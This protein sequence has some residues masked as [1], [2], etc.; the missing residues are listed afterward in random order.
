ML[1]WPRFNSWR[2]TTGNSIHRQ[3]VEENFGVSRPLLPIA[4]AMCLGILLIE[5]LPGAAWALLGA[6]AVAVLI[7]AALTIRGRNVPLRS[8]LILAAVVGLSGFNYYR[9]RWMQRPDDIARL[10]L[11]RAAAVT[12]EGRVFGLVEN[13]ERR[14][15]CGRESQITSFRL[16]VESLDL[17]D[18]KISCSGRLNVHVD[19]WP[20]NV[21]TGDRVRLQG[22][23][24]PLSKPSNPGQF[25]Y[26]LFSARSGMSG[27]AVARRPDHILILGKASWAA[28]LRLAFAARKR[29]VRAIDDMVAN[30]R[31]ATLARC[32]IVGDQSNLSSDERDLMAR[33]GIYHLVVVSGLHMIMVVALLWPPLM[34]L[35]RTERGRF[36]L[37]ALVVI[38]YSMVTG[39]APPVVRSA[40][41]VLA[42]CT[43]VLVGRRPDA[44]SAIALAALALLAFEPQDLFNVGF[45]LS[46][47]ASLSLILLTPFLENLFK[48]AEPE[49][50]LERLLRRP[51]RLSSIAQKF[52]VR[53]FCASLGAW[54]GLVPLLAWQFNQFSISSILGTTL[55]APAVFLVLAVGLPGAVI[56][57]F[58]PSLAGVFGAAL[59]PF[60]RFFNLAAD[61]LDRLKFLYWYVPDI[62]VAG[63]LAFYAVIAA[64]LL[65]L[66]GAIRARWAILCLAAVAVGA[67][68]HL[69]SG[70]QPAKLI[71]LDVGHGLS[72]IAQ[73]PGRKAL[74]F[75]AGSWGSLDAG[76]DVT[77]PALWSMG[78]GRLALLVLSHGHLDHIEGAP[79]LV[80]RLRPKRLVVDPDFEKL[81]CG[82]AF[83]RT[84][85]GQ[86]ET[87]TAG[88][89]LLKEGGF[90]ARLV[91]PPPNLSELKVNDDSLAMMCSFA[92]KRILVLSDQEEPALEWMLN[93]ADLRCDLLALPHHGSVKAAALER[94]LDATGARLAV[95]SG[96]GSE[97]V[98][99]AIE[100][101]DKRGVRWW[102]TFRD[103]A[104]S[105]SMSEG[106]IEIQGFV[107]P[108]PNARP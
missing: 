17:A 57:P 41:M 108:P 50:P 4:L 69:A 106:G 55:L 10:G 25:D 11:G 98:Q 1:R 71:F 100:V 12:L 40:L 64:I 13:Y 78:I 22:L 76:R 5:Y 16:K 72:V 70:A 77:A 53:P 3:I 85:S 107:N 26:G 95:I 94:L 102:A 89:E 82:R 21:E 81:P 47:I 83:L 87:G 99:G 23:F 101:L 29:A 24:F 58:A 60:L 32:L 92:G 73:S 35:V 59:D 97:A 63:M 93:R 27:L 44:L 6:A 65:S 52:L 79:A 86:V 39:L 37:T 45:Q 49:D 30:P 103:G 84:F 62:G 8:A 42:A 2:Q 48:R 68:V 14:P 20:E 31:R 96:P 80:N 38:G 75:D 33:T 19:G 34:V 36:A 88:S 66:K 61:L 46:F 15:W 28:P 9:S 90:E 104:I 7:A 91:F 74:V 43:A 18:A 67:G 54:L 105:A 56:T 51:G